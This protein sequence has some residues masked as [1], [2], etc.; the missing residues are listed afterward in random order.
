MEN[1]KRDIY[2]LV[3]TYEKNKN[4]LPSTANFE[5]LEKAVNFYGKEAQVDKAIEEMSELT[6]V[7]LKYRRQPVAVMTVFSKKLPMSS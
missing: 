2:K 5:L 7:L 4:K 1:L 3:E 6:K